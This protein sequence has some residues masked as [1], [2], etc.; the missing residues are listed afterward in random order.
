MFGLAFRDRAHGI[1]VGGD[2]RG[3]QASP[4]AG[5]VSGDGGRSWQQSKTPPP[6]Y[7]SGVAWLPHSRSV[8]LAVGPTGTDLTLDAGR[9][10]RAA[11]PG[12]SSRP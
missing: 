4:N 11:S 12:W 1:A 5:A 6:S 10:R 2:Y 3:G 7:R 9:A 8:A